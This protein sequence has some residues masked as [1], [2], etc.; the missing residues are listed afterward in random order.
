MS[1]KAD[2]CGITAML[3]GEGEYGGGSSASEHFA[4]TAYSGELQLERSGKVSGFVMT[5][6]I[7]VGTRLSDFKSWRMARPARRRSTATS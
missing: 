3:S 6:P 1:F 2:D 5:H 7:K 4:G